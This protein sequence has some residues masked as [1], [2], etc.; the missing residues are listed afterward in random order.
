MGE[1]LSQQSLSGGWALGFSAESPS[2]LKVSTFDHFAMMAAS[3]EVICC[4]ID[5]HT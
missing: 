3:R 5:I 2:G 1:Q 4:L